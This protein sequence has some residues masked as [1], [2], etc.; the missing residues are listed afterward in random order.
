MTSFPF[1]S[2]EWIAAAEEIHTEYSDRMDPL[3]EHV[4]VNVTVTDAPFESGMVE[5]HIDST[6]GNTRPQRG[7]L[8]DPEATVTVPYDIARSL[9]VTQ[10]FESVV[11]AFMTGQIE[12]EGDIT[13]FM[14][15][16]D[17]DPTP[18]QAELGEEIAGRLKAITDE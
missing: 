14:Y 13:R 2:D 10:D 16:Q 11:M 3:E 9:F 8:D 5:G 1:L 12:I 18:E 6:D 17:M 4:R 7:H 15:L